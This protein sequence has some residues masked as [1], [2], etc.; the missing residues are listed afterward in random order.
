MILGALGLFIYGMKVMS[1]GI[2]RLA[3]SKLRQILSAIAAN[4]FIGLFSGFGATA[5]VQ[6]S[7]AVTVMIVSFV[8]ANI[9]NL[10]QGISLI[11]G[12][13]IGTTITALLIVVFGFSSF[14]LGMYALPVIAIAIPLMFS[15]SRFNRSISDFLIG[16]ALLFLGLEAL[17]AAVPDVQELP[18]IEEFISNINSFGFFSN[19]V[20]ILFGAIFTIVVQSSTVAVAFTLTLCSK[21]I[22]GFENA[23]AIILGEN[24]GTTITA[25]VAAV[26]ANAKA[27]RAARAHL[28]F[29]V[30]GATW[31]MLIFP[32]FLSLVNLI[33]TWVTGNGILGVSPDTEGFHQ[34]LN[35]AIT[36]F[37]ITFNV[38]NA[39]IFVWFIDFLV[40]A[41]GFLVRKKNKKKEYHL[42]YIDKGLM[43]SPELSLLE[44]RKEVAKFGDL[45]YR[46]F[47]FVRELLLAKESKKIEKRLAKIEKYEQITD[48]IEVE[49]ADYLLKV[50]AGE[51][52]DS[53][54]KR[55]RS[56]L[57][58]INDLERIADLFYQMSKNIEKKILSRTWF[59]PKQRNELFEM[60][61]LLDEAMVLMNQNLAEDPEPENVLR[62][63]ELKRLTY[64]KKEEIRVEHLKNIQTGNYNIKSGFIYTELFSA[65]EKVVD[66]V[67]NV[68]EASTGKV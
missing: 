66:Y 39:L 15:G 56:M 9:I 42:E 22:I 47:G 40:K 67:T 23:A 49:I 46:M 68:S 26:V 3:G 19:V 64:E 6:S 34:N 29:N 5:L 2:Q 51:L 44:A 33:L 32:L 24:I 12:A 62:A 65:C 38:V 35:W 58:I 7:S 20:F 37:H 1:E 48:R 52:A 45:T 31:V 16:F 13:N 60:F 17:K 21:G 10:R 28:L 50:S 11:L 59:A 61:D 27:K 53:S 36:L 54:S 41:T 55:V 18:G 63:L 8:N 30:L 43:G 25:N 4:R 57:S 14:H